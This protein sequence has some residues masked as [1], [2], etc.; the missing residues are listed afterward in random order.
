[1]PVDDLD[2]IRSAINALRGELVAANDTGDFANPLVD[3]AEAVRVLARAGAE[4]TVIAPDA[5]ARDLD[6]IWLE[7]VEQE[8]RLRDY[9]LRART[10]HHAAPV[11]LACVS[12]AVNG[13]LGAFFRRRRAAR[14]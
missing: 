12:R 11:A 10:L 4:F 9:V 14:S 8:R 1:V 6:T 13:I 2:T 7:L 3:L 5:P